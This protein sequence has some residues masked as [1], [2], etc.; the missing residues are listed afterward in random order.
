MQNIEFDVTEEPN[1]DYVS[2]FMEQKDDGTITVADVDNAINV[3]AQLKS[4]YEERK[5][6]ASLAYANYEKQQSN[7]L[8]LL[9]KIGKTSFKLEGVGTVTKKSSLVVTT[10]KTN[11]DKAAL[12]KWLKE[13]LGADG[14]LAYASVNSQSLNSLYNNMF[15]ES[16]D[17]VNFKIDGVGEPT[18][19]ETLSFRRSK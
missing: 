8:E 6:A 16:Q 14:F 12:F 1:M 7:V 5:D 19:R 13:N 18:V 10:P 11:E 9:T 3:L 17:K 2:A 4:E 15:E